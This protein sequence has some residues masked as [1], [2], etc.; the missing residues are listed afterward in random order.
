MSFSDETMLRMDGYD[1]C[2]L[3]VCQQCGREPVLAY[4]VGKVIERHMADGMSR[5]EAYEHFD[6]NQLGAYVGPGTPVFIEME[7]ME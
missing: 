4:D 5:D 2:I 3:G 1:D 7:E 6:F